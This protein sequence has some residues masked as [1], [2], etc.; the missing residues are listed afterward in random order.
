MKSLSFFLAPPSY[1]FL[2]SGL[3]A[4]PSL[5]LFLLSP[6]LSISVLR[7]NIIVNKALYPAFFTES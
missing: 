3:P 7:N 5:F 6:S 4:P 2:Y 1:S